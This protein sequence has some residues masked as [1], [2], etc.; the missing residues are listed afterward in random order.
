MATITTLSKVGTTHMSAMGV[1]RV[2]KFIEFELDYAKALTAKGSGLAA[3]D[4]IECISIP[5]GS[6]VLDAGASV[7]VTA[8]STTLTVGVGYGGATSRWAAAFD[9][10]GAAGTYST[11]VAGGLQF[12]FAAADT[13]DVIFTTLTGTLTTGKL[14]VWAT[15]L[16][17][18]D[19][20]TPGSIVA[21]GS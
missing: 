9:G 11:S 13:V 5:P 20:N 17:I 8:D 7:K 12:T 15:I 10:K 6:I 4:V 1:V 3:A 14:R 18:S 2:P 16:D 19:V 21:L